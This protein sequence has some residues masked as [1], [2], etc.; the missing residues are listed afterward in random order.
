VGSA[1]R[2]GFETGIALARAPPPGSY[3]EVQALDAGGAV[4]GSSAPR[5]G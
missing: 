4:I 5:K 1:P 3:F 2:G